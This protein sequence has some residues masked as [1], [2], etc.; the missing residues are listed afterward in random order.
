MKR[1][2]GS[3]ILALVLTSCS[4]PVIT[5]PP[6]R[7]IPSQW[8]VYSYDNYITFSTSSISG[9]SKRGYPIVLVIS[10]D[11]E[12]KYTHLYLNWNTD[13]EE[14]GY[15]DFSNIPIISQ[16]G[17]DPSIE[18]GWVISPNWEATF[19]KDDSL[20]LIEKLT[21]ANQATFKLDSPKQESITAIFNIE[22]LSAT[23]SQYKDILNW[24][25]LTF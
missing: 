7:S 24:D 16:I 10:Y 6:P 18:S 17:E 25:F 3:L 21:Q 22:G 9:T 20:P 23:L 5:P 15:V 4:V 2:I 12:N 19:Y 1:T 13:L 14:N 8:E 11:K